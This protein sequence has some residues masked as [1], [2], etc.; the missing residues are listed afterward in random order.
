MQRAGHACSMLNQREL[1]CGCAPQLSLKQAPATCHSQ[2][3][4]C[5]LGSP[6]W[7]LSWR[8]PWA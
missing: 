2:G 6:C 4:S 5:Q 1:S 8:L 3:R 7:L